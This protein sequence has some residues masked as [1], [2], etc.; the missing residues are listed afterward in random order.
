MIMSE[1]TILENIETGKIDRQCR[2]F[3]AKILYDHKADGTDQSFENVID[4]KAH[5]I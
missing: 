3:K 1:S 2:C 5:C 4:D